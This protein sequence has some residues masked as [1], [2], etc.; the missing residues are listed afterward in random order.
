MSSPSNQVHTHAAHVEPFDPANM[1]IS[2]P[3]SKTAFPPLP[4]DPDAL[5]RKPQ[6]LE[7][8]GLGNTQFYQLIKDGVVNPPIKLGRSSFWKAG[9]IREAAKKIEEGAV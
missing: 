9:W 6:C 7:F 3:R 8:L 5:A 2:R 1:H 4:H